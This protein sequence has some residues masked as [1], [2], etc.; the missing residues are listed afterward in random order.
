MQFEIYSALSRD[1]EGRYYAYL[2]IRRNNGHRTT[3]RVKNTITGE[4]TGIC[5]HTGRTTSAT[6]VCLLCDIGAGGGRFLT[7]AVGRHQFILKQ[8]KVVFKL[9]TD[10][11]IH[12]EL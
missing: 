4:P 1:L 12:V 10:A 3:E 11:P 8:V 9:T 6:C 2:S 5:G 7:A